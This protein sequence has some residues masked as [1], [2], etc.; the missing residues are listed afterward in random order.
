LT[1]SLTSKPALDLPIG[2]VEQLL[3]QEFMAA[4]RDGTSAVIVTNDQFAFANRAA[5]RLLESVDDSTLLER[6]M[7]IAVTARI[8]AEDLDRDTGEKLTASF[9]AL[10]HEGTT[11]GVLIRF[12]EHRAQGAM[13]RLG[14][15]GSDTSRCLTSGFLDRHI[16]ELSRHRQ[17]VLIVGEPGVGKLSIARRLHASTQRGDCLVL[18]ASLNRDDDDRVCA[19]LSV[20]LE[21][22]S[23]SVVLHHADEFSP[24]VLEAANAMVAAH[25]ALGARLIL[26]STVRPGESEPREL[27]RLAFCRLEVPPLRDRLDDLPRIAAA[28]GAR[29]GATGQIQASALESLASYDWLGNIRELDG[30]LASVFASRRTCD[31]ARRDLPEAYQQPL[32]PRRLTRMERIE[33]AAIAHALAETDGN[34]TLAAKA[35][36]IGRAT[37]YRKITAYGLE[38]AVADVRPTMGVA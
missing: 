10:D 27:R 35:L 22:A 11:I 28:I 21:D 30:V 15:H 12:A 6:A 8:A 38:S 7:A 16:E 29:H 9:S 23:A 26:T 24:R 2:E 37:L 25:G 13:R 1:D 18:D 20:A 32:H 33:R 19:A 34:K 17:P 5:A 3:M 36:E 31:I 14:R 4:T